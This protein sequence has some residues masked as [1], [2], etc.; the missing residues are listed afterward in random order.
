VQHGHKKQNIHVQ[1]LHLLGVGTQWET[2]ALYSCIVFGF[3]LWILTTALSVQSMVSESSG[4]EPG[5]CTGE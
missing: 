3:A 2:A 4:M 1:A 5:F